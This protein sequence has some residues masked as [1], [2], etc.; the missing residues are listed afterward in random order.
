MESGRFSVAVVGAGVAGLAVTAR[1]L[2]AGLDV[3]VFEKSRGMGGRLAVRRQDGIGSFDLG[4]Q[5][6]TAESEA[7]GQVLAEASRHG[8]V[9]PWD[10]LLT[11]ISD[12]GIETAR[13]RTRYVGVPGM[14]SWVKA[15]VKQDYIDLGCQISEVHQGADGRWRLEGGSDSTFDALVLAI[16]APQAKALLGT[17]IPL[18]SET[19]LLLAEES[20]EP[21]WCVY[22]AFDGR[23]DLAFDGA[24]VRDPGSPFS[25]I[26][27]DSS[28]PGRTTHR[29][30]WVLHASP[31]WSRQHFDL[32]P[33]RV[34][35]MLLSALALFVGK[36]LP[37]KAFVGSHR[38]RYAAPIGQG[39]L[40]PQWSGSQR[41]G[42]VGDWVRGGR[43]EGAYL[44]GISMAEAILDWLEKTC[45]RTL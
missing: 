44:A 45:Y 28:K 33:Q 4:A 23:I 34:S 40:G 43:V 38:W 29:D 9:A 11:H 15:M 31:T 16:P 1:L 25:W 17:K 3:R 30:H 12:K 18:A 19:S 41:V 7:F 20:M 27:R 39:L 42:V 36:A 24:F 22:A 14:N 37:P 32:D 2:D 21:C 26:A 6:M 10:G 5:F 13:T 35:E 8:L